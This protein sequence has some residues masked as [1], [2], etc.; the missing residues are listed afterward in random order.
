M[1]ALSGNS[2]IN[3]TTDLISEI[4]DLEVLNLYQSRFV[5]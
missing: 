3:W 4:P 2:K 5:L 1:I